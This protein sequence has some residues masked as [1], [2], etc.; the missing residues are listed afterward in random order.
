[1]CRIVFLNDH[2]EL[3]RRFPLIVSENND[4][5]EV[6][7]DFLFELA[8][9]PGRTHQPKTVQ[10]YAEHLH[11]WFDCLEQS[12][13]AWDNITETTIANYRN[14]M[15]N[16]P[17][18]HT[19]RPYRATTINARVRTVCSFYYWAYKNGHTS[20]FPYSFD[21]VESL[22]TDVVDSICHDGDRS[23]LNVANRLTI[24]TYQDLPRALQPKELSLL[25]SFLSSPY[26]LMALWALGTGMRRME[27]CA[28]TTK[29]VPTISAFDKDQPRPLMRVM[30]SH[31]K[32]G[33][34][35]DVYP[36]S[37]LVAKTH[38]YLRDE[39]RRLVARTKQKN[40]NY[41]APETLFIN[42]V[43]K[44]VTPLTTTAAFARAF[45]AAGL[46][47]TL[48]W[49]RHTFALTTLRALQTQAEHAHLNPIKTLQL[50]L[51]HQSILSTE[52]YLRSLEL[53]PEEISDV[54]EY[55]YGG[56]IAH[57]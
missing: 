54:V 2:P 40:R 46:S 45:R 27:I 36:P 5:L 48:H 23:G 14:R 52:I 49:L 29:Q 57:A 15:T 56:P 20:N 35:R 53:Y 13:I 6:A 24:R 50:M 42:R 30:L 4:I 9:V 26:D 34:P 11:D 55:L 22:P 21:T 25:L 12:E 47:G 10:T 18:P 28:L 1:M 3:P 43:G 17:S 8:T 19:A 7:F 51:G 16:G 33:R 41:T 38:H 31:T 39:R 44:P 37:H 32:G